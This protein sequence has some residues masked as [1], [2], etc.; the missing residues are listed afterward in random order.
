ML[1]FGTLHVQAVDRHEVTEM[2]RQA[3]GFNGRARRA[4]RS[5]PGKNDLHRHP[6]RQF[7]NPLSEEVDLGDVAQP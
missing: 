5:S 2:A 1:P 3:P 6:Y 4:H 7:M